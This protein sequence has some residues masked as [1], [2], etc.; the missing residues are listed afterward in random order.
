LLEG[1]RDPKAPYTHQEEERKQEKKKAK[2]LL[3]SRSA[4]N[5][6]RLPRLA[7]RKEL[8]R[9]NRYRLKFYWHKSI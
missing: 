8:F 4:R 9:E 6:H 2:R 5:S 3:L 1:K 7:P